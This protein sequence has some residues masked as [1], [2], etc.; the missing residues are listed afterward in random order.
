MACH[1]FRLHVFFGTT[2]LI[3][4]MGDTG[5]FNHVNDPIRTIKYVYS[6]YGRANINMAVKK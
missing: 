6:V 4:Q 5:D 1:L 3:F 2:L